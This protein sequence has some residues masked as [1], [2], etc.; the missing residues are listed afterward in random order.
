MVTKVNSR[1]SVTHFLSGGA[2]GFDQMAASLVIAKKEMGQPVKLIFALPCKDQ[3][4]LWTD[5]QKRLYRQ[6]LAEADEVIYVSGQY[7]NGCMKKRNRYLAEHAQYCL[8]ALHNPLS[9]TG[10]TVRFARQN[11]VVVINVAG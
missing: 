11:G 6:L 5:G 10:Q 2:L 1:Y 3:D 9:G 7:H 4:A 8:C